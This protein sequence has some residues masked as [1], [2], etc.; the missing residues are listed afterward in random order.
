MMPADSG[1]EHLTW[2]GR[3]QLLLLGAGGLL[4]LLASWRSAAAFAAS[5][6]LSL[7]FWHLHRIL[8][9]RMLTPSLRLRWFYGVLVVLKLAL[10]VV[11]AR[12]IM[13]CFPGETIPF[14]VGILLFVGGILLEAG[15][16]VVLALTRSE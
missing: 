13:A 4:W 15:R 11:G 1:L 16:L 6:A 12:A 9:G 14:A 10:L 3:F 7:A 5:G 2:I 8:V